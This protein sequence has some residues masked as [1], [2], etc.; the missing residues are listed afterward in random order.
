MRRWVL[1]L[2]LL[3]SVPVSCLAAGEVG[4]I[5]LTMAYDG[6][7]VAGGTV[8]LYDVSV[9]PEGTNPETLV[10]YVKDNHLPGQEKRVD[11][12]GIVIFDDLIPGRYLLIQQEAAKGFRPMK[13][14]CI[15]LTLSA[16]GEQV[17]GVDASPKMEPDK[18]LP[19]TGQLIWPAWVL[20]GTGTVLVGFGLICRKKE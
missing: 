17:V 13:P 11:S 4:Y 2:I 14:F 12:A 20:L 10:E 7:P 8:T 16:D 3:L 18:K 5:R 19:Q 1:A 15:R 9:C 6:Q